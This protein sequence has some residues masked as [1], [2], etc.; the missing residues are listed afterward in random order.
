MG[1]RTANETKDE[2]LIEQG[3]SALRRAYYESVKSFAA[4]IIREAKER[5]P[6][7]DQED[8]RRESVG[9]QI[10]ETADGSSWVIYTHQAL[11]VLV[12]SENWLAIED[13][14]FGGE[15]SDEELTKFITVAAFHALSEDLTEEIQRQDSDILGK[16]FKAKRRKK[17]KGGNRKK[18]SRKSNPGLKTSL[19]R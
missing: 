17:G 11:D 7:E 2:K 13:A 3:K 6:D 15:Y 19:L 8:E 14:G 10:H 12:A 4:D 9:E 5:Y 16:S 18:N 1:R